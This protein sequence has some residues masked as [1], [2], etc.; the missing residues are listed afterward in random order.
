MNLLYR[1]EPELDRDVRAERRFWTLPP[2]P[3]TNA[4]PYE[5]ADILDE[6]RTEFGLFLWQALRDV[7]LWASC[8]AAR[9][10][11]LFAASAGR[12]PQSIRSLG[13]ELMLGGAVAAL[14]RL[15]REPDNVTIDKVAGACVEVS[16]WA[17]RQGLAATEVQF[18][19]AAAL[20]L[21]TSPEMALFAGRA[22]RRHAAYERSVQWFTRSLSLARR[23]NDRAAYTLTLIRWGT[24]ELQRSRLDHAR[25][26]FV[27]AWKAAKRFKLRRLGAFSRHDL[28]VLGFE[29]ATFDEGLAHAEAAFQLYGP[30]NPRIPYLAHDVGFLCMHHGYFSAA[31]PVFSAVLPFVI[32]PGERVQVFAHLARTLGALNDER[33][34]EEAAEY[35]AAEFKPTYPNAA[36]SLLYVARGAASAGQRRRARSL[37]GEAQALSESRG[38]KS[39]T[40]LATQFVDALNTRRAGAVERDNEPPK[41]VSEFTSRLLRRLAKLSPSGLAE[42]DGPDT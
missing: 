30:R 3:G 38:E 15:G 27:R 17:A 12:L 11:E 7:V 42:T 13:S 28:L 19:E 10:Q 36:A 26:L 37:A 14:D 32:H 6:L 25:R 22:A 40:A 20:T 16:E 33:G 8:D 2:A 4:A 1:E 24:L 39:V 9:R 23:A 21:P 29:T 34:F 18:A 31:L 35:V 41:A 5:G